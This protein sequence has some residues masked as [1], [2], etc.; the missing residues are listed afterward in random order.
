MKEKIKALQIIHL[1]ITLGVAFAY[2][3]VGDIT[4]IS[5]IKLPEIN[6]NSI[7]YLLIPIAAYFLSNFM[8]NNAINK[9]DKKLNLDDKI[10]FYQ[11]ASIIRWAILEAGAFIILFL[12][13]DFIIFGVLIILYLLFIRPSENKINNDLN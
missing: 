7:V 9:I 2:F 3:F 13:P 10:G 8:F 6:S 11:T 5:N 1:A 4:S 12:K